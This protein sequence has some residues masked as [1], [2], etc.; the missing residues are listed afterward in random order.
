MLGS[1]LRTFPDDFEAHLARFVSHASPDRDSQARRS[2][3]TV[4]RR[5]DERQMR[6]RPDWTYDDAEAATL[7][8]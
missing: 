3:R 1:I 8:P 7:S 4:S 5:Y 6:K 2:R